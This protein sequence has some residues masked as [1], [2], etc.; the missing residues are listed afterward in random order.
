MLWGP[1]AQKTVTEL[2][3]TGNPA[4]DVE[5]TPG[6]V[7]FVLT[8]AVGVFA[9]VAMGSHV[10]DAGEA[11][12][13]VAADKADRPADGGVGAPALSKDVLTAVDLEF[14]ANGAVDDYEMAP[15]VSGG[16]AAI[17]I[18]GRVG[19]G[20]DAR[21]DNGQVFGTAAGHDGID[22]DLFNGGLA[23]AGFQ[24]GDDL[25]AVPVGVTQ[26]GLNQY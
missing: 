2:V 22:G 13:N 5:R 23:A 21:Y 17:E 20:L 3:A 7:F 10:G 26:S 25:A 19:D 15:R 24:G 6:G 1:S 4:F 16:L 8:D 9:G 11:A 12:T 18:V 14:V